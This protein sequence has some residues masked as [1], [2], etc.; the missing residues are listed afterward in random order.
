[1]RLVGSTADQ[2][3]FHFELQVQNLQNLDGF[4]DDFGADAVT[5]ENCDFHVYYLFCSC[6]RPWLLGFG[7]I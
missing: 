4:G 7:M 2:C 1:M 5:R 3:A 6:L